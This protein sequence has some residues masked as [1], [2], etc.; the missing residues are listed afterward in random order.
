MNKHFVNIIKL[1]FIWLPYSFLL[2]YFLESNIDKEII[3]NPN[4][5]FAFIVGFIWVIIYKFEYIKKNIWYLLIPILC[6]FIFYFNTED[7]INLIWVFKFQLLIILILS[8]VLFF[9][10]KYCYNNNNQEN[11][12]KWFLVSDKSI[13]NKEEDQLWLSEKA[14]SFSKTIWNNWNDEGFVFWLVAPWGAWKSSFLNLVKKEFEDNKL[15]KWKIEIF[16]FHPWYFESESILL[17]KFLDELKSF[18]KDISDLYHPE[19]E[20]D[21]N[22]L[23]KILDKKSNDILW[24]DLSFSWEKSLKDTKDSI[25]KC[26]W[27]IWKKIVIIIDDLDRISSEKLK[28]IFK[29]VDLCKDFHNTNFVLCYDLQNFN[30]IDEPLKEIR[31]TS[32]DWETSQ[33][34]EELDNKN[35]VRYIEKI[36]NVQFNIYPKY[37]ELKDYFYKIFTEWELKFSENSKEWIKKWI[38]KLFEITNFR[39]WWKYLSDIRSIKRIYNNIVITNWLLSNNWQESLKDLFDMDIENSLQFDDLIKLSI[40]SL[41]HNDLYT[42][43]YNEIYVNKD[44]NNIFNIYDNK[45]KLN[46]F[47][48]DIKKEETLNKYIKKLTLNK[49]DLINNIFIP[50]NNNQRNIMFSNNLDWYFDVIEKNK[51]TWENRYYKDQLINFMKWKAILESI[52]LEINELYSEDWIEKYIRVVQNNLY[53]F[54]NK[55]EKSIEFVD[56]MLNNFYLYVEKLDLQSL[57]IY[58]LW[59]LDRW[60]SFDKEK[61]D[62]DYKYLYDYIYWE[63]KYIEKWVIHKLFDDKWA[64]IWLEISIGL[65]YWLNE[66]RDRDYC[67]NFFKWI[68]WWTDRNKS[69]WFFSARISRLIYK[70]FKENYI[71]KK[72]NLFEMLTKEEIKLK[73]KITRLSFNFVIYQLTSKIWYYD[74]DEDKSTWDSYE[75]QEWWIKKD[76]NKYYFDVCFSWDKIHYFFEFIVRYIW[77]NINSWYHYESKNDLKKIIEK[78]D[79]SKVYE[80]FDKELLI[81]F[82]NKNEDKVNAFIKSNKEQ[83]FYDFNEWGLKI[84]L[85]DLVKK[86]EEIK[87]I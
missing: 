46:S 55:I 19:I 22:I 76:I 69:S 68:F 1:L 34:S 80:I 57:R 71:E 6:S 81:D 40:L 61:P 30:N 11:I 3:Q 5:I 83:I 51:D 18:I 77:W 14:E 54:E 53:T 59:I 49:Q 42:D 75:N 74:Y 31:N 35:L 26:L 79:L 48:K 66:K 84:T 33:S 28:T 24:L 43:I 63:W 47:N 17:E 41:S 64:I 65:F 87:T 29:I 58:T 13:D 8:I 36:I 20:E 38:E 12:P 45:Y 44:K 21:L 25:N 56:Y 52:F 7:I 9:I 85:W 70:L 27:E 15:Y 50:S 73:D 32:E 72:V 82:L 60:A 86:L 37:D 2:K 16:E 67:D 4:I 10:E 23:L 78:F 39:I 62:Y